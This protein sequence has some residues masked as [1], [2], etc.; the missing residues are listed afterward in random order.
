MRKR[1]TNLNRHPPLMI[2]AD[3]G[4]LFE[5]DEADVAIR[6]EMAIGESEAAV[7]FFALGER[8]RERERW[9]DDRRLGRY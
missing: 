3:R 2:F 9:I 8:E 4:V 5:A 1:G 7:A 6:R